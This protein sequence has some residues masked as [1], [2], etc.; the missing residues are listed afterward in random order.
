MNYF[1][2]KYK[3]YVQFCPGSYVKAAF[4]LDPKSLY[5]SMMSDTY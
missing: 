4:V 3:M 1:L 5:E 2:N